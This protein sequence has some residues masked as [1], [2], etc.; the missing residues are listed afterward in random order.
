MR[1]YGPANRDEEVMRLLTEVRSSKSRL[2]RPTIMGAGISVSAS[3][4]DVL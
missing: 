1:R 3:L 2:A 4:V